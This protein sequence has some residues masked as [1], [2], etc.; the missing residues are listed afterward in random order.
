MTIPIRAVLLASSF[1][2]MAGCATNGRVDELQAQVDQL[3]AAT[4]RAQQTADAAQASA[5]SA[6]AAASQA[7]ASADAARTA[8]S[9][10]QASADRSFSTAA[11][12][13]RMAKNAEGN[14]GRFDEKLDEMFKKMQRK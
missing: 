14:V 6:A 10:A 12:A 9:Q 4:A 13:S 1:A 5:K 3:K 7:Q 11:D 8:A 2:L